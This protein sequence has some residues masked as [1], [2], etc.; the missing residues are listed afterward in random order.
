MHF[1]YVYIHKGERVS[2]VCVCM[3]IYVY[4]HRMFEFEC[5]C[6]CVCLYIHKCNPF[7]FP[8]EVPPRTTEDSVL[9]LAMHRESWGLICQRFL[10]RGLGLYA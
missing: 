4:I 3:W 2:F 6:V 1:L 8:Q 10:P 7:L 5:A 9:L